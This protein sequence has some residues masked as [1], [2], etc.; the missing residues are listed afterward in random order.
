MILLWLVLACT[1]I[2][3][4]GFFLGRYFGYQ[5]G[6]EERAREEWRSRY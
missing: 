6:Y 1:G 4:S 3:T 5:D 2:F